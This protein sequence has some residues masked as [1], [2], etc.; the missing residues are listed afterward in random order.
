MEDET[1]KKAADG[2]GGES[3]EF[4]EKQKKIAEKKDLKPVD[5]TQIKYEPFRKC[6]YIEVKEISEMTPEQVNQYRKE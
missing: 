3:S 5:H 4:F 2:K 6:F 1:T